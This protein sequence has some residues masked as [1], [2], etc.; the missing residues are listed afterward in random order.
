MS[1]SQ[2][3]APQQRRRPPA[4]ARASASTAAGIAAER[5]TLAERERRTAR[6]RT[7]KRLLDRPPASR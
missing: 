2:N 5:V 7:A 1:Q 4:G 3:P 6:A